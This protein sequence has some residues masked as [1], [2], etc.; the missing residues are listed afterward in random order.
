MCRSA[1]CGGWDI[2]HSV[3]L[4]QE[5]LSLLVIMRFWGKSGAVRRRFLELHR[6]WRHYCTMMTNSSSGFYKK[7]S[8]PVFS[9]LST[10]VRYSSRTMSN[11]CKVHELVREVRD[12]GLQHLL[13]TPPV[14]PCLA[15]YIDRQEFALNLQSQTGVCSNVEQPRA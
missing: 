3:A 7:P 6:I 15:K 1:K 9:V 5:L 11:D 2:L 10:S 12:R 13:S 14:Q 8:R 4:A